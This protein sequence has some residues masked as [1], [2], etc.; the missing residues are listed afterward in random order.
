[1]QSGS[2]CLISFIFG[3]NENNTN[4]TVGVHAGQRDTDIV[5]MGV[6][7][8]RVLK[9]WS[10]YNAWRSG[11]CN[12]NSLDGSDRCVM[13]VY[14]TSL[15][16]LSTDSSSRLLRCGVGLWENCNI[17]STTKENGMA[18]R[19]QAVLHIFYASTW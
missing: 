4:G 7:E 12:E 11:P 5:L 18:W 3:C 16:L 13:R 6:G 15:L 10:A 17:S 2:T 8:P 1:M 14:T 19:L 9:A